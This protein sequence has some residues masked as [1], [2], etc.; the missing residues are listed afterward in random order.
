MVPLRATTTISTNKGT[1][2]INNPLQIHVQR[3]IIN[4]SFL[5]IDTGLF[6]RK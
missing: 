6:S 1:A 5:A 4:N 3:K 2:A